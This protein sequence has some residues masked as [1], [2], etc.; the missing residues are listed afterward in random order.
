MAIAVNGGHVSRALDFYNKLG[1][2]FSIGKTSPWEEE[3]NP[4][5]PSEDT[6]KVEELVAFKKVDNVYLVVPD[7]ENG[8]ITY[9]D[10]KWRIVQPSIVTTVGAAGV[11]EGSPNVALTSLASIV[12]GIKLRVNNEYE[13][14]V[15]SIDTGTNT[16]TLDTS[17]P[18]FIPGGSRVE[19]GAIVE[20][21]RYV[22]ID[23][24][25]SYDTFPIVTYRQIGV[26]VNVQ[27]N[28]QDILR[29][30]AY[31]PTG[32]DEYTDVG[33]LEVIDNRPPVTR[34]VDQAE[35]IGLILQF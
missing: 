14:K 15:I 16:V 18:V 30:A 17:A 9:R 26:H 25:L 12:V 11:S 20:N 6:Y 27:P 22:Y 33:V 1:K 31:S 24:T 8:T 3:T 19:S 7:D 13:G 21:A 28:T 32:R 5:T 35:Q 4:P 23:C 29:S 10:T 34:Q 2:Y